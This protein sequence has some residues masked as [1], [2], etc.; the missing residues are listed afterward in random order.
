MQMSKWCERDI[1]SYLLAAINNGEKSPKPVNA[2]QAY[3]YRT[4]CDIRRDGWLILQTSKLSPYQ[5]IQVGQ[6]S[7]YKHKHL[8]DVDL[9]IN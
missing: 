9:I 2:T 1:V 7:L 5:T 4:N 8:I 6:G 3:T